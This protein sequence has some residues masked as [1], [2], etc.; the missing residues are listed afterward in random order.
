MF[1]WFGE[2]T[3]RVLSDPDSVAARY[4][5]LIRDASFSMMTT[6]RRWLERLIFADFN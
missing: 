6:Q 2:A 5:G 1:D 3:S 4:L